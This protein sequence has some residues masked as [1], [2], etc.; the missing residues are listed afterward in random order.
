MNKPKCPLKPIEPIKPIEP[1][2]KWFQTKLIKKI[3]ITEYKEYSLNILMDLF[4]NNGFDLDSKFEFRAYNSNHTDIEI[5]I[6]FFKTKETKNTDYNRLNKLYL[7]NLEKYKLE[8]IAYQTN[9]SKYKDD[10]INY[11]IDLD[12]YEL[13]QAKL[14]IKKL[15]KKLKVK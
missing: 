8:N 7:L 11:N 4:K 12:K 1:P 13:E 3:D 14:K 9:L 15:E 6:H 5:E 10:L 2:K